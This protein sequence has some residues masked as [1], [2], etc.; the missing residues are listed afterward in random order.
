MDKRDQLIILYDYYGE[1]LN[2]DNKRFFED[3]YFNNLSL[4]EIS[5]NLDV[6][7]SAV[8][9]QIKISEKKLYEYDDILK[10]VEKNN[11]LIKLKE[12]IT[13]ENIRKELD[14]IIES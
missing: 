14:E 4:S 8:Q 13:D 5:E 6:S 12:K 3:Y 10:L 7:R 2:D 1:L 9:K 11:K